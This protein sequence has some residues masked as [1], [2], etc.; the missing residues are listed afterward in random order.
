M[1][2]GLFNLL[3]NAQVRSKYMQTY[4]I[5]TACACCEA[6]KYFFFGRKCPLAKKIFKALQNLWNVLT[7]AVHGLFHTVEVQG[8]GG[9]GG[10]HRP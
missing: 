8:G 2:K 5:I 4:S 7:L 9:G 3:K 1:Q 10:H 6:A